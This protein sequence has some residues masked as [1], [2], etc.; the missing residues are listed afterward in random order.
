MHTFRSHSRSRR[1]GQVLMLFALGFVALVAML[2]LAVDGGNIYV[3]RR[4][5]Q[6]AADTGS[7]A[8]ARALSSIP[9]AGVQTNQQVAN[10]LCTYVQTNNFGGWTQIQSAKYVGTNGQPLGG[11][12]DVLRA[13]QSCPTPN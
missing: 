8:A 7:L 5:V 9:P 4:V 3:N 1:P 6:T 12:D 10:A 11:T 2:G 13:G